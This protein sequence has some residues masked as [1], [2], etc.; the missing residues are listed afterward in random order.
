M[1]DKK[2]RIS[3]ISDVIAEL[4]SASLHR[5]VDDEDRQYYRQALNDAFNK[6]ATRSATIEA[7]PYKVGPMAISQ[8]SGFLTDIMAVYLRRSISVEDQSNT[9]SPYDY[10]FH[11]DVLAF[12]EEMSN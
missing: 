3:E 11:K 12:E 7:P 1:K 5:P 8:F 10:R 2:E 6:M 4:V 9:G